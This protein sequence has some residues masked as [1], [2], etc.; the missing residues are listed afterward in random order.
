[1][2]ISPI[3]LARLLLYSFYLGM[4]VG[5]LYDF[6]RIL[7]IICGA[8]DVRIPKMKVIS[9]KIPTTHRYISTQGEGEKRGFFVH[10]ANF[11]GDFFTVLSAC[12]GLLVLNYGYNEGRF[13]FFTVLGTICGFL[14]YYSTV[15]RLVVGL[16]SPIAF[17]VKYT[18]LSFFAILCY[19]FKFFAKIVIKNT[20]KIYNLCDFALEKRRKKEYNINEKVFSL[21][22]SKNGFSHCGINDKNGEGKTD[23][24]RDRT[25]GKKQVFCS[26][27]E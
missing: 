5:V 24:R 1:M 23:G 11:C 4:A 8:A 17:F 16:L 2:E 12:L 26:K 6:F 7:K 9:L 25:Y 19:P 10:A 22:M 3:L 14:L 20:R 18:I 15:G 13:R 27:K 21:K